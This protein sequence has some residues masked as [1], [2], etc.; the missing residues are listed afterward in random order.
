MSGRGGCRPPARTEIKGSFMTQKKKTH[1]RILAPPENLDEARELRLA[2]IQTP[3]L[4]LG[5]TPE[6]YVPQ[7][8]EYG[9][10]QTVTCEAKALAYNE[11]AAAFRHVQPDSAS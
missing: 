3:V 8:L 2:G 4:I 11:A 10:T 7:L 1:L 9:I 5:H 6:E